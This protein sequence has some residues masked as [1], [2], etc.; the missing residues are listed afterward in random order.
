MNNFNQNA[1]I[2][3]TG[4]TGYVAGWIIKGL[5]EAGRTVHATVRNLNQP[6][7]TIHL[8]HIAEQTSG[9]LRLFEADLLDERAFDRAMQ[10]C[11]IVIHTASPFVV[12]NYQDA[13]K[14]IVQPAI[15]G[16]ENVLTSVNRTLSV[17]RV[18]L[19]SSI[20]AT[21]GDAIEI[22][23]TAENRFDESHWNSTSSIDHQPYPYSKVAA[24]R[25]AWKM[26]ADQARWDLVCINP[27]LVMGP[28]LT[29]NTQSGSVEVLKQFGDGTMRFGAP[30]MWNG[31]VDVRDVAQAHIQAA[32]ELSAHGRYIVCGGTL[33]LM[34]IGYILQQHFGKKYPFPPFEVPKP[35]FSL[36]APAFGLSR[37]FVRLNMGY[38]IYF[39]NL[40]SI[41][42]L[43]LHYH[44]IK[45]SVV[46]H[47]Q[48][49]LDDGIIKKR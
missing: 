24:E 5:L 43:G 42:E 22:I 28:S 38:P 40:R 46:E 11:E 21:Y 30:A 16:T 14:D 15:K 32:Q 37:K 26:Q 47:F 31:I 29:A 3:V 12:S 9:T 10:D 36:V 33:S 34:D 2:L 49:L 27:A 7:K 41:Q 13:F 39:N 8:N 48:Q 18:V 4:A 23:K 19:T 17:K 35:L 25:T 20:A 1:P 44:D 6:Y 45:K